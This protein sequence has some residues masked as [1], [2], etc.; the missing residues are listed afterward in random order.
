MCPDRVWN[1]A[2]PSSRNQMLFL[3]GQILRVTLSRSVSTRIL[4]Q[5]AHTADLYLVSRCVQ[6]V[7]DLSHV[8]GSAFS[9]PG[10]DLRVCTAVV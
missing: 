3:R 9:L 8:T 1:L 10:I 5:L 6:L 4:T 2:F 7:A